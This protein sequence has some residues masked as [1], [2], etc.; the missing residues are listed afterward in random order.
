MAKL[1]SL[2]QLL[3]S[4]SPAN[5]I[6]LREVSWRGFADAAPEAAAASATQR[7]HEEIFYQEDVQQLLQTLTGMD[8]DKIF[9]MRRIGKP[10]EKPIYQF[11]TDEELQEARR[12]TEKRARERLQMPPVMSE[13]EPCEQVLEQDPLLAGFDIAK[14]VFTDISYGIPDRERI[15]VVREVDG[16]LRTA[17]WEEKDRLNQTYLPREGRTTRIPAMFEPE[18]L[19]A[20]LGPDKYEYILDRNCIQFEPDHPVY[21]RTA[22]AVYDHVAEHKQYPVLYSTRHYGP[23]VFHLCLSHQLDEFI[24]YTVLHQRDLA[25]AAN[26]VRIFMRVHP[27]SKVL[28]VLDEKTASDEEI[29]QGF[30][31]YDA[32][33]GSKIVMALQKMKETS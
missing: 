4:C 3:R 27:D 23:L 15:I 19:Q 22:A 1:V 10:A 29:I 26:A 32:K 25:T 13:R 7:R 28:T 9:R 2:A 14:Y 30:A 17:T 5:R 33:K 18:N 24:V 20:V 16:T 21:I 8:Y 12:Q 31:K 11:M 6:Q